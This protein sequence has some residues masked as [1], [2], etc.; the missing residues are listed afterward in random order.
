MSTHSCIRSF[1]IKI[2]TAIIFSILIFLTSVEVSVRFFENDFSGEEVFDYFPYR[3]DPLLGTI[4]KANV[5]ATEKKIRDDKLIFSAKYTFD[6]HGWRTVPINKKGKFK[7]FLLFFGGSQIFGTGV[8]DTETIPY[9]VAKSLSGYRPYNFS[10][11]TFGPN[12]YYSIASHLTQYAHIQ[13]AN[14][15]VLFQYFPMAMR[16]ARGSLRGVGWNTSGPSYRLDQERLVFQGSF[17]QSRPFLT[18]IFYLLARL[19]LFSYFDIDIP[20]GFSKQDLELSCELFKQSKA[21]IQ[22]RFPSAKFAVFQINVR[23]NPLK[24]CFERNGFRII[25]LIKN[26]PQIIGDGH[27]TAQGNLIIGEE[28]ARALRQE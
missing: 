19:H 8:N 28:L 18:E 3:T 6:S 27:F 16:L 12:N 10:I 22:N 2:L 4:G 21:Q 11:R 1:K 20:P 13:E 23:V 24:E 17:L 14:G 15:W 9:Y 5:S 26:A 7:K 25:E